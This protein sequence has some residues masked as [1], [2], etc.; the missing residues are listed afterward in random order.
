MAGEGT[1]GN[2][3]EI[4]SLEHD[5]DGVSTKKVLLYGWDGL[6]KVRIKTDVD[7]TIATSIAASITLNPGDIQIG[8]V[9]I[10]NPTSEDR[11]IVNADGT[12][13][14]RIAGCSVT[15]PVSGT[16]V[17]T[18]PDNQNVSIINATFTVPVLVTNSSSSCVTIIACPVTLNVNV[19]NTTL[20][21]STTSVTSVC[22]TITSMPT[23]T[24]AGNVAAGATDSGNPIKVGGKYVAAGV[25]LSDGQRGDNQLSS[26]GQLYTNPGKIAG[27]DFTNDAMK[28][29]IINAT[30][31][32]PVL[33]TNTT[34][35]VTGSV[36]TTA[37]SNQNVSIINATFT[38]PV[39]VTTIPTITVGAITIPTVTVIVSAGTVTILGG[40]TETTAANISVNT[41]FGV[42]ESISNVFISNTSIVN[43]LTVLTPAGGKAIRVYYF[44][45]NNAGA[46]DAT[47]YWTTGTA[48]QKYPMLLKAG[49]IYTRSIR[50]MVNKYVQGNADAVLK[51]CVTPTCTINCG[52]EY[53]EV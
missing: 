2:I 34:L 30:F 50:G 1:T 18:P 16:F 20:T 8:A 25:T 9:E 28:V 41:E 11:M 51:V 4:N 6:N 21:V 45:Y 27:E 42:G 31:T 23:V 47:V 24:I 15:I 32:V 37:P 53:K 43:T 12:S 26:I 46:N 19:T 5:A 38:I 33:I 49:V 22:A 14:I 17:S 35:T 48:A 39:K 29:S 10:K 52:F 36:T 40:A 7:G 3:N 44:Y 13:N